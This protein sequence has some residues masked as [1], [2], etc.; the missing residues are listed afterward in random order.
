MKKLESTIIFL[1]FWLNVALIA[2]L[3]HMYSFAIGGGEIGRIPFLPAALACVAPPSGLI[4]L[5]L[6]VRRHDRQAES[7]DSEDRPGSD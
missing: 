7:P 3:A 6:A 1:G 4:A 5:L 2:H